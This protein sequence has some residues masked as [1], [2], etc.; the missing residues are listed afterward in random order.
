MG[1][2][3]EEAPMMTMDVQSL[4]LLAGMTILRLAVPVVLL[5]LLG[6]LASR[7]NPTA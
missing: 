4:A 7:L 6:A 5:F 3:D 2:N 1:W